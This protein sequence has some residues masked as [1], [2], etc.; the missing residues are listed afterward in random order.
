MVTTG[1]TAPDFTLEGAQG[2]EIREFTLSAFADGR[3]TVLV[4]YIH[5]FSPVCTDQMCEINDMEFLTFNDDARVLGVSTDGPFSH[6]EFIEDTDISYPLL[7][8]VDKEV[9]EAYGMVEQDGEKQQPKRGVVLLDSDRTVQY[10]WQAADNWDAWS[11]ETLNEIDSRV[12]EL[13]KA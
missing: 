5:D 4:F 11:T 8:D 3:P 13:A 6:R 12:R 10:R 1:D 9:Y 2:E 7:S